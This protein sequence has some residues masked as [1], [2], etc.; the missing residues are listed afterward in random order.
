MAA[1][2]A[3]TLAPI[4]RKRLLSLCLLAA[5]GLGVLAWQRLPPTPRAR[6]A[7]RIAAADRLAETGAVPAAVQE[8]RSL[9]VTDPASADAYASLGSAYLAEGSYDLAVQPLEMAAS[10]SPDRPHVLCRL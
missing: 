4:K 2:R 8:L 3:D 5:A 10:L 9:I 1:F 7:A 6:E